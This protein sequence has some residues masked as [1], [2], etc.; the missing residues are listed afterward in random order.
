MRLLKTAVLALILLGFAAE[1]LE[2]GC[3]GRRGI[4][5]RILGGRHG[6]H[7]ASSCR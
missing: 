4:L 7:A 3:G 5:R 6:G 1:L 2:A